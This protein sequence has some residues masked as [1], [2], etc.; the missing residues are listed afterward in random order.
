MIEVATMLANRLE[1]LE[2]VFVAVK[3]NGIHQHTANHHG[4]ASAHKGGDAALCVYLA[5]TLPRARV[6]AWRA[7]RLTLDARLDIVDGQDGE[8]S[9]AT[10]EAAP[11]QDHERIAQV[12]HVGLASLWT[13]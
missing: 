10:G 7:K 5:K 2:D 6:R 11:E 3:Y 13:R 8:P 1:A 9:K 12:R 4:R